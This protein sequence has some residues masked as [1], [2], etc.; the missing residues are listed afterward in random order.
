MKKPFKISSLIKTCKKCL[1]FHFVE[2]QSPLTSTSKCSKI[3][4][5]TLLLL[6]I[7]LKWGY[8]EENI[9]RT[10]ICTIFDRELRSKVLKRSF[11]VVLFGMEKWAKKFPNR[12]KSVTKSS[13][14]F[15]Q[16]KFV[17]IRKKSF[18]V[19]RYFMVFYGKTW[20]WFDL[21]CL[22]SRS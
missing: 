10:V 6:F 4:S 20:I 17:P 13:K 22:L 3:L 21:Y 18:M 9:R 5:E 8:R 12:I 16:T 19:H 2:M 11:V 15:S 7:F 14:N 1:I